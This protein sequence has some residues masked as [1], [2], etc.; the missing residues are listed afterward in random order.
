MKLILA[1]KSPRRSEILANAGYNFEICVSDADE[2]ID[3]SLPPGETAGGL[4]ERKALAAR[5]KTGKGGVVLAADTIVVCEGKVLG[6]PVDAK[7]AQSM[8]SLL[9]GRTHT[10]Y[11][12]VYIHAESRFSSFYAGTKVTFFPLTEGEI[13]AYIATHEPFDKAG[14]YGI[15]GRGSV[16]VERIDGDYYN[17]M[18][19]PISRVARELKGFG[20]CPGNR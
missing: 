19:L 3:G 6:K 12:G 18:G 1:S 5:E 9:S 20:I 7:D 17:V 14:A 16:L 4:A 13:K 15:Q 8:L 11:T 2:Q 10:V